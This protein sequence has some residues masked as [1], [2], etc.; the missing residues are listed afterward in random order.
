MPLSAQQ[1]VMIRESFALLRERLEPA[2][3]YFYEAL[4]ARDPS[5]R[6]MFR[7]DLA[8][9][10][11]KF[12][13]TLG[14]VIENIDHPEKLGD[15]FEELGKGHALIGV[16]AAHFAPMG[17]A[18]IDTLRNELGESFT[19]ELEV[20]WRAAYEELSARVIRRGNID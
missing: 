1:S 10:G 16:K 4:F 14:M 19:G 7:D 13:T 11:M 3:I 18:L 8:G 15:R 17:E 5:L 2:S 9:Q 6:S 20:A 12:M